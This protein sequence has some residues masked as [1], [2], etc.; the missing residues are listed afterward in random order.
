MQKV[1]SLKGYQME[2]QYQEFGAVCLDL[3]NDNTYIATKDVKRDIAKEL[4]Q[5]YIRLLSNYRR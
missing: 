4:T 3:R 1:V 2:K 5:G